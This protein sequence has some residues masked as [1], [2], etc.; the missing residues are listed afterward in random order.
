MPS[1]VT[2]GGGRWA[3]IGLRVRTRFR[4]V[5]NSG[6]DGRGEQGRDGATAVRLVSGLSVKLKMLQNLRTK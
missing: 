3:R 4:K 2:L 1:A 5:V 6:E